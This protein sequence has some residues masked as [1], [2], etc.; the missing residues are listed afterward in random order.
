MAPCVAGARG[1]ARTADRR[2]PF[3]RT[4]ELHDGSAGRDSVPAPLTVAAEPRAP[5]GKDASPSTRA[6]TAVGS[7]R[8][9][10]ATGGWKR[11]LRGGPS[12][13]IVGRH[14]VDRTHRTVNRGKTEWGSQRLAQWGVSRGK[15][16]GRRESKQRTSRWETRRSGWG[17][18][19]RPAKR[20]G[21]RDEGGIDDS[22]TATNRTRP[23]GRP[24]GPRTVPR[25]VDEADRDGDVHT[26]HSG[27]NPHARWVPQRGHKRL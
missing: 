17:R 16:G 9:G 19:R 8:K 24:H 12:S 4:R 21:R 25:T 27:G 26:K 13:P 2:P 5:G 23:G 15:A 20:R 6:G 1:A 14:P 22:E 10:A 18:R 3:N 11:R 7:P